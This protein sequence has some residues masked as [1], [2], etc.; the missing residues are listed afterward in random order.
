MQFSVRDG[1]R[2]GLLA[3]LVMSVAACG[4]PRSG[5]NKAEIFAG[6]V[7]REGDAFVVAVN[8]RVL[9]ATSVAPVLAFSPQ[10]L[11][12]GR[13]AADTIRAGDTLGLLIFENVPDG[14][15]AGP[16]QSASTLQQIQVDSAGNIFV[17]FAGSVRAAG[18]TPEQLRE[19]ITRRLDAQ[20]PD[21]QVVVQRLAGDGSSVTV[22]GAVAGQGVYPIEGSTRTLV[23]MIARAGGV[24]I[25][26]EAALVKVIRGSHTG[27]I[28]L[29]EL[30]ENPRADIA[31]R[32]NDR[33]V[34]ERDTRAFVALGATGQQNRVPFETR[35]L[36]AIE[37]IA[38]VGG[39]NSALADPTGIF[40]FRN[41]PAEL[42][43]S[44]LGRTDLQGPQRFVYVLDLTQ[45]TGMFQARDFVIR[46]GDTVY[47]TEAPSV[48]WQRAIATLTGQIRSLDEVRNIANRN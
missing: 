5:P 34:I 27:Q 3:V 43:N 19:E 11:T 15:L 7:Q 37:A 45:P 47:V 39:L 36:S 1:V 4:L 13:I 24:A 17:P 31:L 38:R 46:D 35:T 12:A 23:S 8:N 26:P 33:I 21:P 2:H 10:F 22:V 32:P 44:V 40:V 18:K 48:S 25:E 29:T 20:T 16:G 41:E 9:Q 28:W 42:A 30:Y 6:S 14:L